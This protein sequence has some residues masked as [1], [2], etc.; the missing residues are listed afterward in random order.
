MTSQLR[1]SATNAGHV[2]G[3]VWGM[4]VKYMAKT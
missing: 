4:G 2:G 3:V 1:P